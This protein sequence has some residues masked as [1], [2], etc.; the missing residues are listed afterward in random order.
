MTQYMFKD[1]NPELYTQ[2][3]LT[4]EIIRAVNTSIE[5]NSGSPHLHVTSSEDPPE[6]RIRYILTAEPDDYLIIDKS[7][8]PSKSEPNL[9]DLTNLSSFGIS[10][11]HTTPRGPGLGFESRDLVANGHASERELLEFIDGLGE[12]TVD[13]AD[14]AYLM[15]IHNSVIGAGVLRSLDSIIEDTGNTIKKIAGATIFPTG[16]NQ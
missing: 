16:L 13:E 2:G 6:I 8:I 3:Q 4:G 14:P 9:D 10:I 15:D 1:D 7:G 12:L 11:H 5:E